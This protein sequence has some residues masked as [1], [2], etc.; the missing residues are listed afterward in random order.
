MDIPNAWGRFSHFRL[1]EFIVSPYLK[2]KPKSRV[3]LH[4]HIFIKSPCDLYLQVLHQIFSKFGNS[5]NVTITPSV[6]AGL[7]EG[8][9]HT[10]RPRI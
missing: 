3:Y 5:G 1:I 7:S 6:S 8:F 9:G 10:K 4:A 2:E